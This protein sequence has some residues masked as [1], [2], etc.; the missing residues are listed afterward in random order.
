MKPIYIFWIWLI[1][2]LTAINISCA[3]EGD[4]SDPAADDEQAETDQDDDDDS[5]GGD[6]LSDY[7]ADEYFELSPGESYRLSA[8]DVTVSFIEVLEDSRCPPMA[9]C[10]WAGQAI[11]SMEAIRGSD[12]AAEEFVLDIYGSANDLQYP[13]HVIDDVEIKVLTLLP[14]NALNQSSYSALFIAVLAE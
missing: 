9:L 5:P 13:G 2:L 10:L 12:Q 1:S 14:Y 6:T 11:L 8:R 4:D 7:W 3:G